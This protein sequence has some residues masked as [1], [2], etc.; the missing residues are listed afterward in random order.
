MSSF[1]TRMLQICLLGCRTRAVER[2]FVVAH[3]GVAGVGQVGHVGVGHV[4][5]DGHVGQTG[6]KFCNPNRLAN[7]PNILALLGTLAGLE[8]TVMKKM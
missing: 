1:V 4:G 7:A 8:S 2:G 6:L 3:V 5:Q